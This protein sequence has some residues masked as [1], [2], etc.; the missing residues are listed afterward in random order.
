[1][2]RSASLSINLILTLL[3][4]H[5][6]PPAELAG[7]GMRIV[8]WAREVENDY[9]GSPCGELDQVMIYFARAG[10]GTHYRPRERSVSHVPL[11]AAAADHQL[12]CL[13]TGTVR[14]GLER[15]TY[16]V[17]RA[18]CE[19]LVALA[20]PEL[21]I[22]CLADVRSPALYRA[23]RARFAATHPA[24]C[25]RLAYVYQAQRR[26]PRLLAAW[27][28][29]DFA[30][31]GAV[32]RA[33]GRGLRDLYRISGPE[34]DSMCEIARSVPGVLGERMLGGGDV[35]AAAALARGEAVPRLQE[36]VARDFPRRHP[37]LAGRWAVH[38]CR[39]ADGVVS[40]PGL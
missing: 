36:A 26:L 5:G 35:G 19:Q 6:V 11:P 39:T 27:R 7:W 40:L 2:S 15:A 34:L 25:D 21:G 29:G 3:E 4:V 18:E 33:D 22:R 13:D 10:S 20:A 32:L 37:A 9:I 24:L 28:R 12:V 30:A 38:A 17:R 31:V 23:I 16:P 8:D 1:M 14:G